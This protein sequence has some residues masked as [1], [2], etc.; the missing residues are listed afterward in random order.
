MVH[1]LHMVQILANAE[2][3]AGIGALGIDPLAIVAQAVT[4]LLLLFL[5]QKL[6]LKKIVTT[7]EERRKTINRGL[8]LTAEM[9]TLKA[10]LDAKVES[11]L[12][13]ARKEADIILA[14]AR[15][16]SGDMIKTAEDGAN[17]KADALL[18]E[19]EGKI[20]RDLATAKNELKSQMADLVIE[21]TS[22]VVRN[23]LD[24]NGDRKL[25]ERYLEEAK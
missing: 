11:T 19:A 6:A 14:E 1:A 23:S 4:F 12:K 10:D 25:A 3:P 15:V 24:I 18:R 16:E 9:D 17:R 7:L 21:A 22:A 5:I 8:H 2:E 13:A 20:E